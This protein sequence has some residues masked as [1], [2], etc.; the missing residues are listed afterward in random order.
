M[1]LWY[2]SSYDRGIK[3]LLEMWPEIRE[4]YPDTELWVAYGW[5]TF[6]SAFADNPERMAWK[7]NIQRLMEQPGITHYGRVG[8]KKLQELRKQCDIWAYPTDFPEINCIGALE[9]QADGVVPCCT[10]F[11]ALQ[12]SVQSGV[13]VQCEIEDKECQ[14]QFVKELLDLMGDKERLEAERANGKE[15]AKQFTW[16]NIANSWVKH[17]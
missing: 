6:D 4:K 14:E 7:K 2:Q 3:Y 1:K 9:A 10:N 5:Q 11:A 12:E 8:K 16:E 17:F 13:K 15:F